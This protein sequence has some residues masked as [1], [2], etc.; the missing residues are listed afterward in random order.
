MIYLIKN[1]CYSLSN[2]NNIA[3]R[4]LPLQGISAIVDPSTS[5]V[6]KWLHHRKHVPGCYALRVNVEPSPELLEIMEENGVHFQR[7]N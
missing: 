4:R 1:D 3:F 2:L 5:W 6:S 7:D